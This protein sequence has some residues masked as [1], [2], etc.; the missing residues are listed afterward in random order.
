[1]TYNDV[2]KAKFISR[3]NRFIANVELDGK[4][5]ARKF[6][7]DE[8]YLEKELRNA[9]PRVQCLEFAPEHMTGKLVNE[10]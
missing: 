4:K 3:P 7:D 10:S 5:L 9:L 2:V 1:M 8:E 6:T